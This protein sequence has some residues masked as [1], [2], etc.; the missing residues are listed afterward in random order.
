MTDDTLRRWERWTSVEDDF[1]R[2]RYREITAAEI[3]LA[4]GRTTRAVWARALKLDLGEKPSNYH[5]YFRQIDSPMKAYVLGLLAADGWI[6]DE[7]RIGIE[8]N[9]KDQC[10]VELVRDQLCPSGRVRHYHRTSDVGHRRDRVMARFQVGCVE[11]A[12]DLAALSIV[13]RKTWIMKWPEAMPCEFDNSF[14]CG[15]TD[16]DGHVHSVPNRHWYICGAVPEFLATMAQHIEAATGIAPRGPLSRRPGLW[17]IEKSGEPVRALD[18]WMHRDVPGLARKRLP[19]A[20][21]TVMF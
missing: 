7:G 2:L 6:D 19:S 20:G 3:G 15:Y 17:L 14:V 16:G 21:Q 8:L 4:I 10:L 1:I 9:E 5:P 12:R 11:M 18:A 13:P